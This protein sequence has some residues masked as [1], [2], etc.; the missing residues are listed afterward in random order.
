M[1]S[2]TN[3]NRV[4]IRE[5]TQHENNIHLAVHPFKTP[6]ATLYLM[7]T[8]HNYDSFRKPEMPQYMKDLADKLWNSIPGL[9]TLFFGNGKITLQHVGVFTDTEI[10][11]AA[12]PIITEVL[13]ANLA[14]ENL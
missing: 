13:E 5:Q 3:F 14:L 12:T 1:T 7:M 10:V 4:V 8:A 6:N 9:S 11:E 2:P